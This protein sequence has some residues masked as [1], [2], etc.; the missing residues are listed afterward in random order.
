MSVLQGRVVVLTGGTS[1][2]GE[3]AALKLAEM[4]ARMVLVARDPQRAEATLR[5]LQKKSSGTAHSVHFADLSRIGET[6]RVA[7]EIAAAE[8]RIDVLVNNAGVMSALRQVTAE[9]W[10][11]TFATNH[12]AYFVL[13]QGLLDR[14]VASAPA[15]II[16]TASEVHRGAQ[17]DFDDLQS[18]NGYSGYGAYGKSKLA[19]VLFTRELA[20]RLSGSGVTANCL[21]PGVVAS[22]FAQPRNGEGGDPS[23]A[24]FLSSHGISPEEGAETIVYLASSPEVAQ[25]TGQYFNKSRAATPSKEAQDDATAEKLWRESERLAG[26]EYGS[27]RR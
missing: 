15:R 25:V 19:N 16:N 23:A 9:G 21:H 17:L 2:I 13:T 14:L 12:L 1:G 20:R 4:G 8:P 10:E 18:E 22:R 3:A 11:L 7:R 6:K 24:S 5:R 26:I 27:G